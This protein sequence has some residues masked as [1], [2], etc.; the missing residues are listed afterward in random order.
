MLL[1]GSCQFA[2]SLGYTDQ[3]ESFQDKDTRQPRTEYTYGAMENE[4]EWY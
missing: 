2:A 1:F 3:E 4:F